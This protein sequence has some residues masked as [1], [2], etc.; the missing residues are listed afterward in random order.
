MQ[1][2]RGVAAILENAVKTLKRN[3]R[4]HLSHDFVMVRLYFERH[5]GTEWNNQTKPGMTPVAR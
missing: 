4:K 1:H 3:A 2:R 5:D